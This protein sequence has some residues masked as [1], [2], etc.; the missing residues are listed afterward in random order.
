MGGA[1]S[2]SNGAPKSPDATDEALVAQRRAK[3]M[4][5]LSLGG[6][7]GSA[8]SSSLAGLGTKSAA[9]AVSYG[10]STQA[11]VGQGQTGDTQDTAPLTV[12][13]VAAS[14]VA[15]TAAQQADIQAQIKANKPWN[16]F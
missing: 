7:Y 3:A 9:G 13:Q 8:F 15:P 5:L 16:S 6:G 10:T 4:S 14:A 12:T 1:S 11:L 2:L